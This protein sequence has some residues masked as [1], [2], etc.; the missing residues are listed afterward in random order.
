MVNLVMGNNQH[1]EV[2]AQLLFLFKLSL[3]QSLYKKGLR[4]LLLVMQLQLVAVELA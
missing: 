2:M 4:I 3:K 1:M